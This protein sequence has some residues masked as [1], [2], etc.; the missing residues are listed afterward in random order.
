MVADIGNT[1]IAVYKVLKIYERKYAIVSVW[2]L[3]TILV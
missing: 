2:V 3:L 1:L